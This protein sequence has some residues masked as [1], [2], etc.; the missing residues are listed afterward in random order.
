MG[1]G[2]LAC[3]EQEDEGHRR[4]RWSW[5]GL[6]ALEIGSAVPRTRATA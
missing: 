4:G 2:A 1:I 3:R 5:A 6:M